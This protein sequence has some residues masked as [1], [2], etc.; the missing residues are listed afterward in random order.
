MVPENNL[1]EIRRMEG[2]RV[3]EL[4]LLAKVS[5]KSIERVEERKRRVSPITK[6][7]IIKGLNKNPEKLRDYKYRDVFPYDGN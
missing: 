5:T 4:A 1:R 2:L 7:K 6:S 3:T